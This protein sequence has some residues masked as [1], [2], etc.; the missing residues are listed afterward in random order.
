M[1]IKFWDFINLNTVCKK[2]LHNAGIHTTAVKHFDI[3]E[4]Q[5]G[6]ANESRFK[7]FCNTVKLH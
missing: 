5:N 3:Q 4:L 2:L 6:K 1:K 7:S